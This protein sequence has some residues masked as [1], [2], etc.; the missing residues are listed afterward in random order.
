MDNRQKI[1]TVSNANQKIK[2]FIESTSF[3]LTTLA[4]ITMLSWSAI[5]FTIDG[6][7]NIIYNHPTACT[8]SL[9][10]PFVAGYLITKFD[11]NS[12]T[13]NDITT[14]IE[15]IKPKTRTLKK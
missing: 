11:P 2:D 10:S 3:S 6:N 15:D 5:D 13:S 12:E 9:I 7:L 1:K 4:A 8:I 14:L